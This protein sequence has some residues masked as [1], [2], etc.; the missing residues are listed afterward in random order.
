MS[1]DFN[2]GEVVFWPAGQ[3]AVARNAI[4]IK[5]LITLFLMKVQVN[6]LMILNTLSQK[7]TNGHLRKQSVVLVG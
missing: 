7:C 1:I 4:I 2:V 3:I 6:L 5:Y